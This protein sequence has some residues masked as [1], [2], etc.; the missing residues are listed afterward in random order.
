MKLAVISRRTRRAGLPPGAKP[1]A[2]LAQA[3][4]PFLA[5]HGVELAAAVLP[6]A[7]GVLAEPFRVEGRSLGS[8]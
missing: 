4:E 1:L 3:G 6:Q 2:G 7:A 5:A 8:K